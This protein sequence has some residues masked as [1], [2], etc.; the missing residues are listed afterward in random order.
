MLPEGEA[1]SPE[2][3]RQLLATRAPAFHLTLSRVILEKLSLFLAALDQARRQ[4]NLTGPLTTEQLVDHALE[5]AFGERLIPHGTEV[6][7]IGSGAGFPGVPLAIVRPDI[8]VTPVE[9]RQKR[10]EFLRRVANGIPLENCFVLQD[11]VGGMAADSF[12][13]ATARAVGQI[14][15]VLG[16]APFLARHGLFL[17]WTTDPEGLAR[18]LARRFTLEGELSIPQSRKKVIASFRKVDVPRGTKALAISD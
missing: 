12:G 10:A 9:P 11:R 16:E 7:D 17:A 1:Q 13:V 2:A 15:R 4:T 18:R 6:I 5:S 8:C 14:D 3:F